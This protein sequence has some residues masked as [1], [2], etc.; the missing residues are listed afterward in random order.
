MMRYA[1]IFL[2]AL[3]VPSFSLAGEDTPAFNGPSLA[4]TY[5]ELRP[6]CR[7]GESGDRQLDEVS[8]VAYCR[9]LNFV[10]ARLREHDWCWNKSELIWERCPS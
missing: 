8:I 5:Y 3:A 1:L 6:V 7:L 10:G 4:E 2:F 9:A